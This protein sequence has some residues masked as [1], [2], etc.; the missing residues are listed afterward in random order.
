MS[1][2]TVDQLAGAI[3]HIGQLIA[4]IKPD[5]WGDPTPCAGWDVQ[6]LVSHLV[7]GNAIDTSALTARPMT[8][9]ALQAGFDESAGELVAAFRAPGALDR[10]LEIPFGRVP[11]VVALHLR[12]T[13]LLVHGWDLSQATGQPAG[14][15][16]DVVEQALTHTAPMLTAMPDG[17]RPFD[18]P[19]KAAASAPALDRLAF[20][21]GRRPFSVGR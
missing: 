2:A 13:E 6:A 17:R 12:L 19:V 15:A 14:F 7:L 21:L 1:T 10:T 16:D 5:Q 8:F 9:R 20:R 11:G 4:G 18:A 3:A